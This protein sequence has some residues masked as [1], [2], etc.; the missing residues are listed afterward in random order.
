MLCDGVCIRNMHRLLDGVD[1][2]IV[3]TK[4][5]GCSDRLD[6]VTGYWWM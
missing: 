4:K 3:G 6:V 5:I 1:F 2:F